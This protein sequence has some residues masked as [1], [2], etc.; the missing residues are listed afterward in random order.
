MV[1]PV[2]YLALSTAVGG[3]LSKSHLPEPFDVSALEGG[4]RECV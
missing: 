1:L 4:N 3:F 2:S